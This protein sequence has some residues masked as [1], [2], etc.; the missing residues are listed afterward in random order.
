MRQK[1]FIL[2]SIGVAL[3]I[4]PFQGTIHDTQA[5]NEH[6]KQVEMYRLYNPNTGEHFYTAS[7]GE[8]NSLI[9]SGWTY[10]GIG[11]N[12]PKSGTPVYRIYNPNTGD[13]HYTTNISERNMLVHR[14]WRNEGVGWQSGGTIPNLS[15]V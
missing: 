12:A 8:R 4:I 6:S 7:M 9:T 11:W 15:S 13:H 10:E 5:A 3:S 2:V 1:V 14:G